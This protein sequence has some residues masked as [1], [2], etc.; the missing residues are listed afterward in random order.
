M[1]SFNLLGQEAGTVNKDTK[2]LLDTKEEVDLNVN[3][4]R[5]SAYSYLP[6]RMQ[7]EVTI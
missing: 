6:N 4:D 3:A 2:A 5:H 7:D 1:L